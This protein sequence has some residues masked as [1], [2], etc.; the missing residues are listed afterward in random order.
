MG[1]RRLPISWWKPLVLFVSKRQRDHE[2]DKWRQAGRG[3][4]RGS[5]MVGEALPAPSARPATSG[6]HRGPD[7]ESRLREVPPATQGPSGACPRPASP[8]HEVPSSPE[9]SHSSVRVEH[10]CL[11]GPG[12]GLGLR[13]WWPGLWPGLS[14]QWVPQLGGEAEKQVPGEFPLLSASSGW[15]LGRACPPG[16][17]A[18]LVSPR[19]LGSLLESRRRKPPGGFQG[20]ARAGQRVHWEE[21]PASAKVRT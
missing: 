15:V 3:T 11:W 10:P 12:V 17:P 21:G 18:S 13:P 1:V 8:G 6:T 9:S 5:Q 4:E 16:I 7:A 2:G 14:L 19:G 20:R